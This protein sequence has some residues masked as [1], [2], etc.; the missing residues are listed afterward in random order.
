M[1]NKLNTKHDALLDKPISYLINK[2]RFYMNTWVLVADAAE[3]KIYSQTKRNA[4]L[5]EITSMQH[6][7]AHEQEQELT[8]DRPGHIVGGGRHAHGM[9][10]HSSA[11]EQ[12]NVV[13][14]KSLAKHLDQ[15]RQSGE[16]SQ[17]VLFA[18]PSFLGH[19][20]AE[21]SEPTRRVVAYESNKDLV[22]ETASAI[23]AHLPEDLHS[24]LA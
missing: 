14:A 2:G 9:A 12:S 18:A 17:L 10:Q 13:F 3:A 5:V 19:L 7:E 23:K 20:R 4:D 16:F 6:P 22:R 8:S 1:S 11:K 21:L 24:S 15:A